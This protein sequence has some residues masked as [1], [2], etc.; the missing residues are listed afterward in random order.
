M[1]HRLELEAGNVLRGWCFR[2]RE[3]GSESDNGRENEERVRQHYGLGSSVTAKM[4]GF[5]NR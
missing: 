3:G 1:A 4:D 2:S 5:G